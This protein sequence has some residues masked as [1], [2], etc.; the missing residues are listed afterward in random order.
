MNK[1][2]L[3]PPPTEKLLQPLFQQRAFAGAV[4][5]HLLRLF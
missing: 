5:D 4:A 2:M 1:F 3:P